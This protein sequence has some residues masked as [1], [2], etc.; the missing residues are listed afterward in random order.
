[1]INI[2]VLPATI[3]LLMSV[4]CITNRMTRHTRMRTRATVIGIGFVAMWSLDRVLGCDW[5]PT[6]ANFTLAG[7]VI[8]LAILMWKKYPRVRV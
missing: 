4:I 3:Y 2:L 6:P 7:A 8:A 5:M 1:M